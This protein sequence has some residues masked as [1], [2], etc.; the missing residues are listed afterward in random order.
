MSTDTTKKRLKIDKSICTNCGTCAAIYSDLFKM[1][2]NNESQVIPGIDVDEVTARDAM[3]VCPVG[4]IS[5][6]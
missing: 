3:G 5:M 2:E 4:A 6:E 1:D